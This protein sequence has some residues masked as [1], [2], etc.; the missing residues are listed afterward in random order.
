MELDNLMKRLNSAHQHDID[1]YLTSD[2]YQLFSELN[3]EMY[4]L[5]LYTLKFYNFYFYLF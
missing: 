5:I 3:K 2:E 1:K 4:K